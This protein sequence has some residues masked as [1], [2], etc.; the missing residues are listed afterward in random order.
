VG[1]LPQLPYTLQTIKEAL[2]LYPP[3]Y[4]ISR[5]ALRD[6]SLEG[7]P[8]G[9]PVA[10]GTMVFLSAYTLHRRPDLYAEPAQFAPERFSA[11]NEQRL[12]RH[13]YLPFGAGAHTCI[14]NHFA[15]MELHLVLA[16]WLQGYDIKLLPGQTVTLL[17]AFVLHPAGPVLA[18]VQRRR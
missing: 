6:V 7:S 13:A 2:R 18:R 3:A 17:P 10:R 4:V 9:T 1:D 8:E 16:T 11:A 5:Q 12:P 14:G 15:L